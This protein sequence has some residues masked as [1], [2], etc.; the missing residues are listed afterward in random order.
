MVFLQCGAI[1]TNILD[2]FNISSMLYHKLYQF[3]LKM[4]IPGMNISICPGEIGTFGRTFM[5]F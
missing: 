3:K 5:F 4:N 2:T 1:F